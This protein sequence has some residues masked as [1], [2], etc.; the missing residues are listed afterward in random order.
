[1]AAPSTSLCPGCF[2]PRDKGTVPTCGFCGYNP[3]APRPLSLLPVG[4]QLQQYVIGERLG[5]GGFGIT[6]RGFDL[7]L[8]M[9]VAIKEYYPADFVGRS[10]DRNTLVLLSRENGELFNYGLKAFISEARTLAQLQ[11]PNVVRVLNLFAMN[12][13]AYLVMDYYE[14]ET[15]HDYLARQPG[16]KLPWRPALDLLL[17]VLDGLQTVHDQG[18]MHRDVKPRNLYRTH[19]GQTI[20]LDFGAAQQVVSDH[21]RSLAVYTSGYAAY[22]QHIQGRQGPW[23][24]VYGAAATFYFALT[25]QVPPPAL[26]R[27]QGDALK[28]ARHFS[29]D[30]PPAFDVLLRQALAVES[31]QR[32]QSV[33][34]FGQRLRAVSRQEEKLQAGPKREGESSPRPAL[35]PRMWA[36]TAFLLLA[37]VAV[38]ASLFWIFS[39]LSGVQPTPPTPKPAESALA[40]VKAPAAIPSPAEPAPQTPTSSLPVPGQIFRDKLQDGGEGPAMVVIPAGKFQMGSPEGEAGRDADERQ[41]VVVIKKPFA[42]GQHEVTRGEFRQFIEV[43]GHKTD[44]E[45][46]EGGYEGCSITYREGNEWN[47]GY[48]AGYNWW[49]PNFKQSDAHPVVCVSWNDAMA[50]AKWLSRQTGQTYRL[51]TEAEWEYAARAGTTTVRHWGDDPNQ[52]CRYANVA[53]QAA[54]KI[55]PNLTIHACDDRYVNTAPVGSFQPNAWILHDML[56]NVWEWTCSAYDENYGGAE[57]ECAREDVP[58]PRV[59]RGG[60]WDETPAWVR[61]ALRYG[62]SPMLRYGNE[63]FRLARF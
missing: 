57:Q 28:P 59:V 60:A 49:N 58:D 15:L 38:T 54:K 43:S 7:K 29:P 42:I 1:M 63:G 8:R 4:A 27:K 31:D 35:K 17:P 5:Q 23:T 45:R 18:F 40:P 46:N 6:Y 39:P 44:A 34:E 55:F 21:S 52:A 36:M 62:D 11:H 51:P 13:T 30:L 32:L 47:D 12:G 10:S 2:Q 19:Q 3:H 53:D 33:A 20:L 9:K 25:A 41:H 37:A 14:G 16:R 22:E 48:R 56:G 50:Y 26:E 24:D 61:S